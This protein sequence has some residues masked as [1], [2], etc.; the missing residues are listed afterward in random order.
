MAQQE[1]VTT[2]MMRY[3]IDQMVDV[4]RMKRTFAITNGVDLKQFEDYTF[5]SFISMNDNINIKIYDNGHLIHKLCITGVVIVQSG[6]T[7]NEYLEEL[8]CN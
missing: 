3:A 8:L 7:T 4:T 2:D 1:W 6:L 5:K